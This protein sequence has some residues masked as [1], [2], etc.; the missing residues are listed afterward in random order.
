MTRPTIVVNKYPNFSQNNNFKYVS[1]KIT[2]KNKNKN[3]C[4]SGKLEIEKSNIKKM[5][6]VLIL[7][8]GGALGAYEV[9][10]LKYLSQSLR[11]EDKKRND[12]NRPLFDVVVGSS[13]GAVNAA[14]LVHNV[15]SPKIK[16][17][18]QHKTWDQ[19]IQRLY[20]FYMEITE[21]I[22]FHPLW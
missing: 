19:A 2:L 15:I 5:N 10:T 11:K 14:I 12:K 3:S 7:Q 18:D 22:A 8:G 13:M 6:R 16:N 9:G 1:S 21:P 4:C 17:Q 20:D